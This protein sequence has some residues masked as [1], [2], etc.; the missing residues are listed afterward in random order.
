MSDL[1]KILLAEDELSLGQIV[2]ESLE[3]RKFEVSLAKNGEEAYRLYKSNTPDVLVLDVM[4]PKKDGFTL[5]KEIRE[6][7][8]TIPIIFLTAKS[9]SQVGCEG[10]AKRPN[11]YNFQSWSS[12]SQPVFDAPYQFAQKLGQEIHDD[13]VVGS[14]GALA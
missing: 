7:N 8:A 1:I 5:A 13:E 10:Q 11:C 6:E 3:T 14:G 4:M 9:Q 12:L 2:K